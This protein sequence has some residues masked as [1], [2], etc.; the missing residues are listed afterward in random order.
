MDTETFWQVLDTAKYSDRPLDVAA[1]NHVSVLPAE[2][3]LAFG[4][5]FSS[6]R[7]AVY[8]WDVWAAAYLIDGGCSDDRFSDFAA[9]LVA[10]GREWCERAAVCPDVLADQPALRTAAVADDQ[11]VIFDEDFNFVSS[12][13]YD[14]TG[15]SCV[16]NVMH[17]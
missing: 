16:G 17:S 7:D 5:H 8:C 10:L 2:E 3:I 14:R 1:A 13:A 6:L 15:R 12:R 9:G 4:H 11:D